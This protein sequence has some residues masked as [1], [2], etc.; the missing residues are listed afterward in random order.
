MHPRA[1]HEVEEDLLESGSAPLQGGEGDAGGCRD[2]ADRGGVETPHGQSRAQQVERHVR[3][4]ERGGQPGAVG[5]VD[6]GRVLGR[7]G[8][9]LQRT[10]VHEAPLRDD[11]HRVDGLLHLGEQ[12]RR[13]E[14]RAALAGELPEESA[15]PLD[16]FGVEPVRGL[17]E[18][19]HTGIAQESV[20]KSE[21]LAHAE[22]ES[23]D[24]ASPRVGEADEP[25]GLVDPAERKSGG[26][27]VHLQM[28]R[29]AAARVEARR[30]QHGA[31]GLQRVGE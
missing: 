14:D 3:G 25:E 23:A 22:R 17:V 15:H 13:D 21:S 16:A 28:V 29:G 31:D 24:L 8:E 18:N 4:G 27:R 20:R 7:V 19:E 10:L 2:R 12:V 5:G 6:D 26:L 9:P 11:E 1:A 30:L